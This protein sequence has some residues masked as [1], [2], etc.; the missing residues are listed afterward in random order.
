M[1]RTLNAALFLLVSIFAVVSA[2]AIRKSP[3]M[4]SFGL[5]GPELR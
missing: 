1:Y 5:F 2:M 3:T 4:E